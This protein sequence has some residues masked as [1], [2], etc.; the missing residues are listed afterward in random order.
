MKKTLVLINEPF[1]QMILGKNTTLSYI[2]SC[3]ELDHEIYIHNLPKSGL[4]FPNKIDESVTTFYLKKENALHLAK[5]FRRSNHEIK[6][7]RAAENYQK[8]AQLENKKVGDFLKINYAT[9]FSL[10][11]AE[12]DFILQRIEPMKAPFPPEGSE[13]LTRTLIAI[14]KIF[15]NHIF[16]FPLSENFTELEDKEVP[17]EINRI[18]KKE[19]ATPTAQFRISD[20]SFSKV[21]DSMKEK[22]SKIFGDKNDQKIVIKPKNSAQSLGVF[23]LQFSDSGMDLEKL[24]LQKISSLTAAQIYKIKKDLSAAELKELITILCYIQRIKENNISEEK[25][26]QHLDLQEITKSAKELYNAEIL[27]QPF[28]EGIKDGDIRANI[29]K[30]EKENFYCAGY[31]F[32]SGAR[33]EI[34]DDFT[35]C[36]TAGKAVSKPIS[37]LAAA[38]KNSLINHCQTVLSI[39]NSDLREKYK[40]VIELGADFILVGDQISVMLGEINHHCPALIPISEAMSEENYDEGLGFTKRSVRD[41]ITMQIR[42]GLKN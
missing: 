1:E 17:Q 25:S 26:L 29:L 12:V 27:A 37:V 42:K 2:L 6:N 18:L 3:A 4:T 11:L 41:A 15:P 36:Y 22:Y 9:N 5:E 19:I 38:E 14:R 23:A 20:V 28:L 24:K 7:L 10:V 31:T 21:I 34:S 32:R 39:L 35:T 33:E 13:N 16:N 30:D 40:N 8:L